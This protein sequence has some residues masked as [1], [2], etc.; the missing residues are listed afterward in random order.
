MGGSNPSHPAGHPAACR[1]AE[2]FG[3]LPLGGRGDGTAVEQCTLDV[4]SQCQLVN[5]LGVQFQP[6]MHWA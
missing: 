6:M 2:L 5:G 3:L 1:I 4:S